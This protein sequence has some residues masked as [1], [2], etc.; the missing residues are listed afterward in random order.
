MWTATKLMDNHAAFRYWLLALALCVAAVA[1]CVAYCDRPVADSVEAHLGHTCLSL[2]LNRGL[3]PLSLVVV[4]ALFFLFA[5]GIWVLSGRQ[6]GQW[7]E[8]PLLCSWS[9]TWAG[10]VEIVF[11]RIF[12]RACPDPTYIHNHVYGFH[13]LHGGAHWDSFPSGTAAISAAIVTVL[14]IV[15][16]RWRA[17][18]LLFAAVLSVSVVAGN[19]HWVSDVIAGA[20]LGVT[21][22]WSTVRLLCPRNRP[23]VT[24]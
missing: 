19:Y 2:W 22:G 15:S 23:A 8:T 10:A 9:A 16:P 4:A 6:L 3:R 12:G 11:K 13:W 14:W 7:T 1:T 18:S 24:Q 5:C 20:F 21:I 17:A